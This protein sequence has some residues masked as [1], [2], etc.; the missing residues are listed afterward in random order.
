M[1][2][3]NGASRTPRST[4]PMRAQ[5]HLLV[6]VVQLQIAVVGVVQRLGELVRQVDVGGGQLQ[7]GG[8]VGDGHDALQRMLRLGAL[9]A[10]VQHREH[11]VAVRTREVAFDLHDAGRHVVVDAPARRARQLRRVRAQ[12]LLPLPAA[13]LEH[14]AALRAPGRLGGFDGGLVRIMEIL[15]DAG[16]TLDRR[17]VGVSMGG[18]GEVRHGRYLVQWPHHRESRCGRLEPRQALREDRP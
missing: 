3:A 2:V 1:T 16:V 7:A 13:L 5:Q 18:L 17:A 8:S 14:G 9:R 6:A 4:L 10:V 11:L 12:P 15:A